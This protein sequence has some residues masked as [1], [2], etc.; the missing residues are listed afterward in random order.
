[1]R[2]FAHINGADLVFSQMKEKGF[3]DFKSVLSVH[4]YSSS[5]KTPKIQ[6]EHGKPICILA[7]T[8]K[9]T[10]I[11]DPQNSGSAQLDQAWV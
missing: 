10:K 9:L 5:P 3:S 8:D 6:T 2:Y 7:A 11:G 4:T 1:M